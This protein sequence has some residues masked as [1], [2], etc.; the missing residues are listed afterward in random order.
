MDFP[1]TSATVWLMERVTDLQGMFNQCV[2]LTSI[3]CNDDWSMLDNIT[4]SEDMFNGCVKLVGEN[5][6]VYDEHYTDKT[7]AR[8]DGFEPPGYFSS[9]AYT[10]MV[11]NLNDS[12]LT[13][14]HDHLQKQ[15][16]GIIYTGDYSTIWGDTYPDW[17]YNSFDVNT[18]VFDASYKKVRPK[19][20]SYWFADFINLRQ[21]QGIENL[22]TEEVTDMNHMFCRCPIKDLDLSFFDT[23]N[24]TNMESMFEQ[25]SN[26]DTLDLSNFN[27]E[28]VTNMNSMFKQCSNLIFIN[29]SSFDTKNVTDMNSMFALYDLKETRPY[30][31]EM[32]TTEK[33]T[34]LDVSNFNTQNVTDMMSMFWGCGGLT[35]LNINS[36]D[37]SNRTMRHG[38]FTHVPSNC[39]LYLPQGMTVTDFEGYENGGLVHDAETNIVETK[40][41]GTAVCEELVMADDDYVV[42]STPFEA[43]KAV[44][45]FHLN[46]KEQTAGMSRRVSNT[47][48]EGT[49]V[50]LYI[51]FAFDAKQFGQVYAMGEV[52]KDKNAVQFKAVADELTIANRPYVINTNG[53]DIVA[54]NVMVEASK[55]MVPTGVDEMLGVIA[56]TTVP[57]GGYWFDGSSDKLMCVNDND[58]VS[59]MAGQGFFLLPAA[60][61]R[62][63]L[64]ALFGTASTKGDVNGDGEVGIGDIVAVTNVMAGI[65]TDAHIVTS[66]DVNGDG[67]VGIGDIVAITNIMAG[68]GK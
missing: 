54:E 5:G 34:C 60:L 68:I 64:D 32:V 24:V 50:P 55:V 27:T 66:A 7:Y 25:C 18:V 56:Q 2:N 67:E 9:K 30:S 59:V 13:F 12:T 47:N 42:V 33:L 16:E 36:F 20:T 35:S 17:F 41:D 63:S 53:H 22:V 48:E 26:L 37:F 44:F 31:Y 11:L 1:I 58:E 8:L 14:Y 52:T 51:A 62:E 10:Y 49:R 38:M 29:V 40:E 4:S 23:R 65:T 21:I 43:K 46:E 19:K 57:T 39:V 61:G 28:N 3:Y 6:T 15:R 45:K